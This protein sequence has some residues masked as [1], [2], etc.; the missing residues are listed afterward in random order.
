MGTKRLVTISLVRSFPDCALF[1]LFV[2]FIFFFLLLFIIITR[3]HRHRAANWGCLNNYYFVCDNF[4]AKRTR[5]SGCSIHSFFNWCDCNHSQSR[6]WERMQRG[7]SLSKH[8]CS[9]LIWRFAYS[10]FERTIGLLKFKRWNK[11]Q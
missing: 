1:C 10:S 4:S 6:N 11:S 9:S 7:K 8:E 5:L 3:L 2:N